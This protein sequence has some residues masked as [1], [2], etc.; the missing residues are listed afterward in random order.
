MNTP[1]RG[2]SVSWETMLE[3]AATA[4]ANL[5]RLAALA[6]RR[7]LTPMER[8]LA[9]QSRITVAGVEYI[10]RQ[11]ESEARSA[12]PLGELHTQN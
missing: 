6:E 5:A 2:T 12:G 11:R 1:V 7:A 9:E 8:M 10:A 4:R 3:W